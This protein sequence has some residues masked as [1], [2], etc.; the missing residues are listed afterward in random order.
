MLNVVA[1]VIHNTQGQILIAQRPLHKHQGG[2][3]EF[4]GGKVDAHE[5]PAQALVRELQ[6][7]L[8]ITATHY[9]PLL[10][11]EH[12]Y[13]DKS[14]RLQVFRV[15]AFEGEAHGAEGQPTV[16]VNPEQLKSYTFPAANTPILKAALLP[17][18]YYITPEADDIGGD[19]VAWLKERLHNGM[20]L[21]LR[22]KNLSK[23]DY[24]YLAQQVAQ[25]CSQHQVSLMLHTHADLLN[26]IP[27][28]IGV[29]LPFKELILQESVLV[30]GQVGKPHQ[31]YLTVSCHTL[32]E[33]EM[34][35]QLGAD[36]ATLSPVNST[37]SHVGQSGMGWK[38]FGDIVQQAKLP[39]YALGGMNGADILLAQH[40]GAQ[41]VAA[42]RGLFS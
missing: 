6:E 16:W 38:S 25:L 26:Q 41:G 35:W 9:R 18:A 20:M 40:Y 5:T 10:T 42:I 22:A 30:E 7:E 31:K 29:H 23:T 4:A 21:C 37:L 19:L 2:L 11:V 15:T 33:L 34:A 8:G 14:V 17:D 24:S 36:F 1:A 12:H 27:S 28:A 3:W 32:K 13:P 39:V